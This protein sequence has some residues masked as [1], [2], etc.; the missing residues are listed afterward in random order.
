MVIDLYRS[1]GSSVCTTVQLVAAALDLELNLID[2]NFKE[3]D[4]LKPEYLKVKIFWTVFCDSK[5]K[6]N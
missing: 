1:L 3:G 6:I 5:H 2:I 4:H